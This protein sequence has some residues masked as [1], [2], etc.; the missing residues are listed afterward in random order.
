[1]I[2]EEVLRRAIVLAGSANNVVD[3]LYFWAL[4]DKLQLAYCWRSEC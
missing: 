4:Y 1:M 2:D 3:V